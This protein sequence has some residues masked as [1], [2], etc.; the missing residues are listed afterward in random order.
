M[1][2][3]HGSRFV[4][5]I[6]MLLAVLAAGCKTRQTTPDF[7]AAVNTGEPEPSETTCGASPQAW[8]R[9]V[10]F[11]YDSAALR[12]DALEALKHN[13]DRL[14]GV[15]DARVMIEGHCDERGTQEYNLVLGE[16]RAMVVREQLIRLGISSDRLLT[17]S[18]GK[19]KPPRRVTMKPPGARTGVASSCARRHRR[20]P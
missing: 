16:R 2:S 11:D 7:A 20:R 3:A 10:Y 14:N 4:L 18:Y 13:A 19:E 12:P 8:L 6:A 17:I 9:N 15:P 5:V 1:M